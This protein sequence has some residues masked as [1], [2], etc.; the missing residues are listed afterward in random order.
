MMTPFA[1]PINN[2]LSTLGAAYLAGSGSVSLASGY[3]AVLSAKLTAL[4]LPDISSSAPLRFTLVSAAAYS[5]MGQ[6]T[7][8]ALSAIFEATGLSGDILTGVSAQE[9][10]T[11]LSFAA[12]DTFAVYL[13]AGQVAAIQAA[14][15]NL[16]A[17]TTGTN[18]TSIQGVS[19]SSAAP[20][21]NGV[22][23]Y[24]G[25]SWAPSN[26][27][28]LALSDHGGQVYNVSAYGLVADGLIFTATGTA[29]QSTIQV[30]G[31][32]PT[33]SNVGNRISV[34]GAATAG[35]VLNTTV[36]AVTSTNLVGSIT[37]GTNQLTVTTSPGSP[38]AGSPIVIHGAGNVGADLYTT[39]VSVL[40][41][42]ITIANNATTTVT[43]AAVILNATMTLATPLVT[44][45]SLAAARCGTDN[46]AALNALCLSLR[47]H[48]SNRMAPTV[49][50]P[51]GGVYMFDLNVPGQTEINIGSLTVAGTGSQSVLGFFDG[52]TVASQYLFQA[53]SVRT[54]LRDFVANFGVNADPVGT[55]QGLFFS[56]SSTGIG[57]G[58]DI[59]LLNVTSI[60]Q[61]TAL[62]N[63]HYD[64]HVRFI[65]C[66]LEVGEGIYHAG[67]NTAGQQ[68]GFVS[69]DDCRFTGFGF[70][71]A[72]DGGHVHAIYTREG[73]D[74]VVNNTTFENQRA[75][76]Q[77]WAIRSGGGALGT[78][79]L[80]AVN[81]C[82]IRNTVF[83]GILSNPQCRTTVRGGSNY[84]TVNPIQYQFDLLVDG[85]EFGNSSGRSIQQN[86]SGT[87]VS[88][89]TLKNNKFFETTT[90]A[91]QVASLAG[92]KLIAEG[93]YYAN[94]ST[95]SA[96]NI[97]AGNTSI[98]KGEWF[99]DGST[100]GSLPTSSLSSGFAALAG[101]GSRWYDSMLGITKWSDGAAWH[102]DLDMDGLSGGQT[103]I[104]GTASNDALNL[105]GSSNAA[106]G[107]INF[108]FPT[109][110]GGAWQATGFVANGDFSWQKQSSQSTTLANFRVTAVQLQDGSSNT[111]ADTNLNA[112]A[113]TAFQFVYNGVSGN[114]GSISLQLKRSA[115]ITNTGQF[116]AKI[117]SDVAGNPGAA[118]AGTNALTFYAVPFTTSYVATGLNIGN[119]SLVNGTTYWIVVNRSVTA[120]GGN[121]L[122]NSATSNNTNVATSPDGSTWTVVPGPT[123]AYTVSGIHGTTLN[124]QSSTGTGAIFTSTTAVAATFTST[125]SFAAVFT[126]THRGCVN[127]TSTMGDGLGS[128]STWGNGGTFTTSFG[129]A[130][131]FTQSGTLLANMT[132]NGVSIVRSTALNGFTSTGALYFANDTSGS[133]GALLDLQKSSSSVF[134]VDNNGHVVSG[135]STPTFTAGAGAGTSPT[136]SISGTDSHGVITL[137]TGTTPS[138]SASVLTLTF[139]NGYAATIKS[140]SL[141]P[142]NG[143]AAALSGNGQVYADAA[144]YAAGSF[145]V[146][147]GSTNLVAAT[148]YKWAYRVGG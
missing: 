41:N 3:G 73:V 36:S 20:S 89:V 40:G 35:A 21:A 5:A 115:T 23:T 4:G 102:L 133:T 68:Q 104:G 124:A 33:S 64:D 131:S 123:W 72:I 109:P 14:V 145:I 80:H 137:T 129:I 113:F 67:G 140:V 38:A 49:L 84:A 10:T 83:G 88:V 63:A 48:P 130:G 122:V 97:G 144:N 7:N 101:P 98:M 135:G 126:S 128:T 143:N 34:V 29:T 59:V 60:G 62:V 91:I 76:S 55:P 65:G 47:P 95:S 39:V 112:N 96:I 6:L 37:Q 87:A 22:L 78:S 86:S 100:F 46:F 32:V 45:V 134:K 79:T 111:G 132:A 9:G 24:G 11:D 75:N 56:E 26:A 119:V 66:T 142:A 31:V 18:A 85:V 74:L 43:N 90:Q 1:S 108:N 50:F 52:P 19:V 136:I 92:S 17:G 120:G 61:A 42:V 103:I 58:G 147:V 77:G 51:P 121:L 82:R 117:Y 138:A 70:D 54:V 107:P 114:C 146:S 93:N 141:T 12:G 110:T 148:V 127:I 57:N 25:S 44:S 125:D 106:G 15:N 53:S 99:S 28:T 116:N 16:E 30:F 118:L 94:L 105:K 71:F 27:A 69:F 13:T 81:N 2:A 8:P 139:A